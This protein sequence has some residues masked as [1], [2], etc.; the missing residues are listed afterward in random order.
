MVEDGPAG[1]VRL[2]ILFQLHIGVDCAA[3]QLFGIFQIVDVAEVH[4][5]AVA[6]G[7]IV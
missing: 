1:E 2:V 5:R 6:A 7:L 3:H 4:H